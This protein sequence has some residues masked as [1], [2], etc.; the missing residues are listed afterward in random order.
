MVIV[1]SRKDK[2]K[3]LKEHI[4][5]DIAPRGFNAEIEGIQEKHRLAIEEK[6]A[7]IALLNDDLQ[8]HEY[9]NVALQAQ[10]DAYQAELQRCQDSITHLR[11]RYISHARDP[12]KGNIIIIVGKHTTSANDK[13]HDL[14]YYVERIQRRKRNVKLRWFDRHFPHH[15]IRVEIDYPNSIHEFN[16]FEEEVH[17][18]RKYNHFRLKDLTREELYAMG[19]PVSLM[20]RKNK[21]LFHRMFCVC[22]W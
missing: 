8:N 19:V 10:R 9:E 22:A 16:R 3:A 18:E 15:E 11:A 21:I 7:A 6:D 17:A 14:P 2:G 5:K 12:D 1:N 13:F 4:F 20:M